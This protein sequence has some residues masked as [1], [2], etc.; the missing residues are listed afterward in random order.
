VSEIK[1]TLDSHTAALDG[2]AKDVKTLLEEKTVTADRVGR[3]ENWAHN[4]AP[5]VSVKL[6]L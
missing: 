1:Q 5:K 3:L 4:V 2:L 6:E